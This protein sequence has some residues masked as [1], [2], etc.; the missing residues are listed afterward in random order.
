MVH[1]NGNDK[2]LK[3]GLA[4]DKI[5]LI[6]PETVSRFTIQDAK[7]SDAAV[8]QNGDNKKETTVTTTKTTRI[9]PVK[10]E[11][12]K[13]PQTQAPQN[14]DGKGGTGSSVNPKMAGLLAAMQKIVEK[15][16]EATTK[17]KESVEVA[18]ATVSD[19]A[20]VRL[21]LAMI[22]SVQR[23]LITKISSAGKSEQDARKQTESLN[24]SE[25]I[26]LLG[27]YADTDVQET[28]KPM[29]Y[30]DSEPRMRDALYGCIDWWHKPLA[31]IATMAALDEFLGSALRH[32]AVNLA[33][34][35][36]PSDDAVTIMVIGQMEKHYTPNQGKE[37]AIAGWI[38]CK[39]A[40]QRAIKNWNAMSKL[41]EKTTS[42]NG[43]EGFLFV[44]LSL[45][46]AV[47]LQVRKQGG[48][49]KVRCIDSVGLDA[50]SIPDDGE[51]Q[52]DNENQTVGGILPS[53]IWIRIAEAVSQMAQDQWWKKKRE[54]DAKNEKIDRLV[55]GTTISS[56][57]EDQGLTQFLGGDK[58]AILAMWWLKFF[59]KSKEGFL[60]CRIRWHNDGILVEEVISDHFFLRKLVGE[61][62]PATINNKTLTVTLNRLPLHTDAQRAE[63]KSWQLLVTFLNK[64]LESERR[65]INNKTTEG[66]GATTL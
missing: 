61:K 10:V 32:G 25:Q 26:R 12:V 38:F 19:P 41:H 24:T 33:Y 47:L 7:P 63:Q 17:E 22:Q 56:Q 29:E 35:N 23:L 57:L 31:N 2:G 60:G 13:P 59:W 36:K 18:K 54:I 34:G 55:E 45:D 49:T 9:E 65:E 62:I 11:G 30:I 51:Y 27:D 46:E 15:A 44:Q 53:D 58:A 39:E 16:D 64:R 43:D 66:Q 5:V 6:P 50:K 42:K 48:W 3:G 8:P 14:G 40:E 20:M 37:D 1:D 21:F 52:W 28:L 4:G